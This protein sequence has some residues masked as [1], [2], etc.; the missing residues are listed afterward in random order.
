[1]CLLEN[2]TVT[3]SA[4]KTPRCQFTAFQ[5]PHVKLQ[6]E[7]QKYPEIFQLQSA[8]LFRQSHS[9]AVAGRSLGRL[10]R[11]VWGG[12]NFGVLSVFSV[13]GLIGQPGTAG[14]QRAV[15]SGP[16]FQW[17]KHHAISI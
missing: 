14:R 8:I 13:C 5:G 3:V 17:H 4:F 1:M 9:E 11:I 10:P 7:S 15:A 2:H 16:Q 12:G 6:R